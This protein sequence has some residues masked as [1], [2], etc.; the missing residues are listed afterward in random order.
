MWC[1]YRIINRQIVDFDVK[2]AAFD[3][4]TIKCFNDYLIIRTTFDVDVIKCIDDCFVLKKLHL[5]LSRSNNKQLMFKLLHSIAMK[6]NALTIVF[7]VKITAFDV[8]V[9]KC[10]DNCLIVKLLHLIVN[11]QMHVDDCLLTRIKWC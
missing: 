10:T 6:L 1:C 9:I 3:C 7:D 2:N 4:E 11:D 5:I 8:N